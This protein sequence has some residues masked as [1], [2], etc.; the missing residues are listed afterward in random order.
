[1]LSSPAAQSPPTFPSAPVQIPSTPPI[2]TPSRPIPRSP[3]ALSSPQRLSRIDS[4]DQQFTPSSPSVQDVLNEHDWIGPG[5]FL[6]GEQIRVVPIPSASLPSNPP[7]ERFEVVRKLGSGSYAVV[8]LV[9]EI[10]STARSQSRSEEPPLVGDLDFELDFPTPS[11]VSYGREFAIKCLSKA[12]LEPES[13]EAQLFEATIHQSI[14]IH[15]NIVTLYR[16]LET[17]SF[18]LLLLECVPGEDLFYF[19][20]QARD[21]F[22][23]EQIDVFSEHCPS[24]TPPTPSLLSSL[25]PSQLL[26]HT[27]LRLIASMF[28]QMCDAV[29]SCHRVFV[30]HR[31]IKP[32]NFIVTDGYIETPDGRRERKVVVK[33]T[34]FG[35]ATNELESADMGCGS[36]PYMSY[37][38]R[39]NCAP[40]Y[41]TRAADVW[42]LGIVL[43][44]MLYHHNPWSDTTAGACPS[45]EYFRAQPINFFMQRFTGMTREVAEFLANRVFC[46]FEDTPGGEAQRATA[47][48]FGLWVKGLPSMFASAPKT[49]IHSGPS[50]GIKSSSRSSSNATTVNPLTAPPHPVRSIFTPNPVVASPRLKRPSSRPVSSHGQDSIP[51]TPSRTSSVKG[52]TLP[53]L[54]MSNNLDNVFES[55]GHEEEVEVRDRVYLFSELKS[56]QE[57]YLEIEGEADPDHDVDVDADQDVDQDQDTFSR[58]S[59]STRRRKR[60]ARKGKAQQ[61]ALRS[62]SSFDRPVTV[63]SSRDL[64]DDLANASQDLAREISK[65]SKSSRKTVS[66]TKTKSSIESV[67]SPSQPVKK[68]SKWKDLLKMS[69]ADAMAMALNAPPPVP[70][71]PPTPASKSNVAAR[72]VVQGFNTTQ[73]LH[74]LPNYNPQPHYQRQRG[75]ANL[76]TIK[77]PNASSDSLGGKKNANSASGNT[78]KTD[79]GQIPSATARNVSSLI[80]GLS[81]GGSQTHSSDTYKDF[82]TY[83]DNHHREAGEWPRGRKGRSGSPSSSPWRDRSRSNLNLNN[84]SALPP[85]TS[86]TT[87]FERANKVPLALEDKGPERNDRATSPHSARRGRLGA[88]QPSNPPPTETRSSTSTNWRSSISSTATSHSNAGSGTTNTSSSSLFSFGN[89]TYT[90]FSNSSVSVRSVSTVATSVSGGPSVGTGKDNRKFSYNTSNS[91]GSNLGVAPEGSSTDSHLSTYASPEITKA[92]VDSNSS[93]HVV[94]EN[95]TAQFPVLSTKSGNGKKSKPTLPPPANIKILNGVP[96]ELGELPRGW[97]PRPE[98]HVFSPPPSKYTKKQARAAATTASLDTINERPTTI[99]QNGHPNGSTSDL[100]DAD[101][102]DRER[103]GPKKVQKG[104]INSL[105]KMLFTL[106]ASRGSH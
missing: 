101:P 62:S 67:S 66:S 8:Y 14:P 10:L 18:L 78:A 45:F 50:A 71:L 51:A 35:L 72:P 88:P 23:D 11:K 5:L 90:K 69:T 48:E 28:S 55:T 103:D 79:H 26:S 37:E 4:L 84:S 82:I 15:P 33:L 102:T 77:V 16:T 30:F 3:Y 97:D 93:S 76:T 52:R 25:H 94:Q 34:D 60:G 87:Q 36:A 40:T 38:C 58:T 65:T 12:N 24:V 22:A 54:G 42:S 91:N 47:E 21:H 41:S 53:F 32:E 59:T 57:V 1:M 75:G 105:A 44:N 61:A 19:L 83:P 7:A 9:R 68:P 80:M 95:T 74:N 86:K 20:E 85:T 100:N 70:F 43:I 49:G 2:R 64:A 27:R 46:I 73:A 89:N 6:Q 104:Q 63:N 17:D 106:K 39:N 13:L 96:W 29:A 56:R 92:G 99:H 81:A 98:E 31:D